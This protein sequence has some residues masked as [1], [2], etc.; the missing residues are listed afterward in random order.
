MAIANLLIVHDGKCFYL[1]NLETTTILKFINSSQWFNGYD[2]MINRKSGNL[3][4][5]KSEDDRWFNYAN[6]EFEKTDFETDLLAFISAD[7]AEYA[8]LKEASLEVFKESLEDEEAVDD[9]KAI[10]DMGESFVH[11][12]ECQRVKNGG[13]KD[14]IHLIKRIPSQFAVGYDIQSVELDE[15]K[16]YIEVKTTISSKP[17]HFNKIH[18]TPN[19]WNTAGTMK[20]R[21]FIYRLLLSKYSRKLFII[22]DPVGLYKKDVIQMVPRGG[23]D[24]IFNEDAGTEEE[25]LSWKN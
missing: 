2:I 14:I 25:L 11:S 10:G 21:Y 19:E 3:E 18:L 8:A 9:A 4:A 23:A 17:L 15:R 22:Q 6:T 13:R 16:R 1:N 20:D 7:T 12:H 5:V 24:V